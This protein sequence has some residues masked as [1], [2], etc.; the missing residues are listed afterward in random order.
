[1]ERVTGKM[2]ELISLLKKTAPGTPLREGL[3]N[4]LRA[5]TGGLIVLTDDPAINEM[6]TGGFVIDSVYSPASLYELAKMD[7]A[8]I[9]NKDATR[10]LR[11]NTHLNPDPKVPSSETGIRHRTAEQVA[12]QMD[13]LVVCISQRRNVITLFKGDIKYYV[14]ESNVLVGMANQ[15]VQTLDKYKTVLDKALN[16]LSVLEYDGMV[17]I[18]DVAKVL[19]RAE[20]FSRVEEELSKYI[21]ELGTEGRLIQMQVEELITNV[22]RDEERTIMDYENW[23]GQKTVDDILGRLRNLRAEELLHLEIFAR[24]LGY[25]I[26]KDQDTILVTRGYR[27][28]S[29]IPRLPFGVIQNMVHYF[30]SFTRIQ[31]ATV[32][33]LD[34]VEGI[35]ETRAKTIKD[36]LKRMRDQIYSEFHWI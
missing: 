18:T 31:Q 22:A 36:G 12:R 7:G 29:R 13:V 26:G 32:E 6:V 28:L 11:A 15:A 10:I 33:E 17:S 4:V 25:E 8:I 24:E 2:S 5:K 20:M 16:N 3:D 27:L 9:L 19:Q 21:S 30:G 23:G 35:G 14:K 34:E 1:M